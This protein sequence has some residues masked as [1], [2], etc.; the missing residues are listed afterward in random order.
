MK[1][2]RILTLIGISAIFAAHPFMTGCN[3]CTFVETDV[4]G[5]YEEVC[6][7]VDTVKGE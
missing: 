1:V 7:P 2:K 6:E 3:T 4:Q 5:V